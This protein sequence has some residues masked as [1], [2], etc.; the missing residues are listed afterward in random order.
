MIKVYPG[1]KIFFLVN[2]ILCSASA[3]HGQRYQFQNYSVEHGMAQSQVITSYHCDRGYLWFGMYGG[4]L[5]RFDGIQFKNFSTRDGLGN[6][7]VS[8]IIQDKNGLFW[9]GT[10][11]GL[12][13]FDRT[14][15]T[16][17]PPMNASKPL[18]VTSIFEDQKGRLWLGTEGQGVVRYDPQSKTYSPVAQNL[19]PCS[20]YNVIKDTGD[21]NNNSGNFW[22]CTDK[23]L[24]K[25]ESEEDSDRII[26]HPLSK[27]IGS[28]RVY[29]ILRDKKNRLWAS[30]RE[31][32]YLFNGSSASPFTPPTSPTSPSTPT[33]VYHILEDSRGILWFSSPKGLFKL[34]QNS[35][36]HFTEKHGLPV[37]EINRTLE[38]REG[39]IWISTERGISRFRGEMFT[40][41]DTAGGLPDNTVWCFLET[42]NREMW[43][44]T[45][46]GTVIYSAS[47]GSFK[48]FGHKELGEK[49]LF[50]MVKDG[51][52]NI[53]FGDGERIYLFDG[54]NYTDISAK[55]NLGKLELTSIYRE[56]NGITWF[57][58]LENGV[59][60]MDIESGKHRHFTT[61]EGLPDNTVNA[62]IKHENG[63]L[64]MASDGGITIYNG[65]GFTGITS[66]QW[67]PLN[68]VSDILKDPEGHLWI[69]T[70]GGGVIRYAASSQPGNERIDTFDT[71]DGLG[72]NEVIAMAFDQSGR[73]WLGTNKGASVLDVPLF[74]KS[75]RTVIKHYGYEDGFTGIECNQSGV[76]CDQ[77]GHMWFGTIGGAI[78]YDGTQ[79]FPNAVEPL[80]HFT[81]LKMFLKD[82]GPLETGRVFPHDRNHLTFEYIGIS[83]TAP[84][85]VKYRVML[86][87][88]ENTWSPPSK[89]N[90][91][92][93]SNLSPGSYTFKVKAC[94]NDG[95]WNRTP[96]T[97]TF[98]IRTP[99]WMSPWF[100]LALALTV[101]AGI[102]AYI[103]IRF[104]KM[105]RMQ[106]FLEEK[107]RLRTLELEEVNREL[108]QRV[109]ERTEKLESLS[110]E[111]I[112]AKKM[113]AIGTLA[114][115]VAHDL[116]NVL[117]GIVS[118]P[119]IMLLDLPADGPMAANLESIQQSGEK[120][121]A[122]VQDLLT[123][124]RRG[125]KISEVVNCNT[126]VNEFVRSPELKKILSY[127]PGVT[128]ATELQQGLLN[129]KASPIH[130]SKT[131][132]NLVSNAVEAINGGGVVTIRTANQNL[133]KEKG[134]YVS[135]AVSDTGSGISPED[136]EHIFEPFYSKKKMGRSGTGLG[137]TV[138]YGTV[139]DHDGLIDVKSVPGEGSTFTLFFPVTGELPPKD[140]P[141]ANE[142]KGLDKIMGDGQHILI[143]DDVEDQRKI[144]SLML[145]KLE[146]RV[147]AV[148]SGELAIEFVKNQPVDLLVLDMIMDPGISGTET[149]KRILEIYPGQKAII[150]SGFTE[151]SEIKHSHLLGS[152][153]YLKKPFNL[154]D[155]GIAVKNEFNKSNTEEKHGTG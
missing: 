137:M 130:L 127:H 7:V 102:F 33:Y 149:Y 30:T 23:G 113:E 116:N 70:Y 37:K 20:V 27:T 119:E 139:K 18:D 1:F 66:Q 55:H 38:D 68:Y 136:M 24:L 85:K 114:G 52:N 77:N 78:K 115:G 22:F 13:S 146:Y 96:A 121:A 142:P 108:E 118:L 147:D 143:V 109:R 148:A 93:Y 58:T 36:K 46:G 98:S 73:L 4:G 19:N 145:I 152:G 54:S 117:S 134:N 8:A 138:V 82:T 21:D 154:V 94:N 67:L 126:I 123:L 63:S 15:F 141:S 17:A 28:Q 112:R 132:M 74:N 44:S 51:E 88:F 60:K 49:A 57:G 153:A 43:M 11:E 144:T 104:R 107:V 129:I 12:Y 92:T 105:K 39:N 47:T 9:L 14:V 81:G 120:A 10:E 89:T 155:L 29:F 83:L 91:A 133:E 79:D 72:A 100:Y 90:F 31:K 65:S 3:L 97:Y 75:G 80:V 45:D 56:E 71:K 32:V 103:R 84:A 26:P 135:L 110:K 5:A 106:A 140:A 122:I 34:H 128:V 59:I 61:R 2:I 87:G 6:M 86:E 62:I 25:Y 42:G 50:P 150:V 69:A 40:Y 101:V 111:L 48:P 35:L 95:I 76:Y 151:T 124:A 16:A 64:W 125:I 131:L 53:W 99:Y 41:F